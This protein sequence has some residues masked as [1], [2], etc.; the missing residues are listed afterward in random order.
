MAT[1][2]QCRVGLAS[3]VAQVG[4]TGMCRRLDAAILSVISHRSSIT[5]GFPATDASTEK[6]YIGEASG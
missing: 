3:P 4:P 6:T 1:I 2:A 5:S